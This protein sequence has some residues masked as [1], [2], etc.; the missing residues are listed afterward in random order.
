M[1]SG[2]SGTSNWVTGVDPS[3][4]WGPAQPGRPKALLPWRPFPPLPAR[5]ADL[6]EPAVRW[7]PRHYRLNST[8]MV[9]LNCRPIKQLPPFVCVEPGW[10]AAPAA[11]NIC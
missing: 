7:R 2:T 8:Q 6:V 1:T 11:S 10:R 9:P 5:L 4:R 3:V